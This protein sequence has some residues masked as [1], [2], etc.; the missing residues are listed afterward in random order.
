[1]Q[2]INPY[3]NAFASYWFKGDLHIHS[4]VSDGRSSPAE[5]RSRLLE[6][7]FDFASL[8]DHDSYRPSD[9]AGNPVMVGNSEMRSREGGDVL[10]LF[11]G[12]PHGSR[13]GVQ[14]LID[15][16]R[17]ENGLPVL[18]HPRIGEFGISKHHWGYPSHQLIGAYRGYIGIEIY[19]HNVGSGF[20]TAVDRLDALWIAG[21][22]TSPE[23]PIGVWGFAASDAHEL[24][25]IT[26][27]VGI[28]AAAR[29]CDLAS[30]RAAIEA[31]GFYSLAGSTARFREI[32]T[33]KGVVRVVAEAAKM[34]RLYGCQ[35]KGVSGDRRLLAVG[36]DDGKEEVK[37]SY[38]LA[39]TEGFVRIEAFDRA[40]GAVYANP[41]RVL[42]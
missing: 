28:L 37:L 42:P 17:R 1:M 24:E 33:E 30:L 29:K 35:Q 21:C 9:D 16:T 31:G 22:A 5:V 25:H 14:T 40:G 15:I 6:C 39:G 27:D 10:T 11:A 26:P 19:T 3:E 12:V 8:A 18:A 7:G 23:D 36:W 4:N 34:V 41:I 2:I 38:P 32:S 13:A 20:Q